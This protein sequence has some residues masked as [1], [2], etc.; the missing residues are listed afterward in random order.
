MLNPTVWYYTGPSGVNSELFT[1]LSGGA[2]VTLTRTYEGWHARVAQIEPILGIG[3][4]TDPDAER[5]VELALEA[6][7]RGERAD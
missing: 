7:A 1:R 5:A 4:G 6:I 3:V 2:D